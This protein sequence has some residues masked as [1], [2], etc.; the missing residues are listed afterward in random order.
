MPR[1]KL[2]FL[3]LPGTEPIWFDNREELD[4]HVELLTSCPVDDGPVLLRII[5]YNPGKM[6]VVYQW[7]KE[8]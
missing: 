2:D 4:L 6:E 5:E 7:K 1:Y 3:N 8:S